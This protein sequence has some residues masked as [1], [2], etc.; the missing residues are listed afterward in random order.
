MNK[1]F[2]SGGMAAVLLGLVIGCKSTHCDQHGEVIYQQTPPPPVDT[3]HAP[4]PGIIPGPSMAPAPSMTPAP[5]GA[6]ST[7]LPGGAGPATGL[8]GMH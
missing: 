8:P 6:P 2:R 5:T 4:A 1:W 3:H 7:L